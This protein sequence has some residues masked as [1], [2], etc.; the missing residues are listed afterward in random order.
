MVSQAEMDGQ[1]ATTQVSQYLTDMQHNA[2]S[3]APSDAH[4]LDWNWG[5]E[6]SRDQGVPGWIGASW[7]A[8]A[9]HA[10]RIRQS[11][12][13]KKARAAFAAEASSTAA[14]S[15]APTK[16]AL[17]SLRPLEYFPNRDGSVHLDAGVAIEN[18]AKSVSFAADIA[19]RGQLK[20]AER[21]VENPFL[22]KI[23]AAPAV[24]AGAGSAAGPSRTTAAAATLS[25]G[26]ASGA[27]ARSA[28][29]RERGMRRE[30]RRELE[31]K[32]SSLKRELAKVEG[33]IQRRAE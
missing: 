33:R 8:H 26:E 12:A 20:R 11:S 28:G 21:V 31:E 16:M 2:A 15:N 13:A 24:G 17:P 6:L 27:A 32:V 5:P 23:R 7:M 18:A 25:G 4:A 10:P 1:Q 3:R 14:L 19:R 29:N 9:R 22:K 30:Q